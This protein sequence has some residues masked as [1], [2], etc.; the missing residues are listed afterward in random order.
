MS[1]SVVI[2]SFHSH[3]LVGKIVRNIDKKIPITIIE[4]SRNIALKKKLEK[5]YKNLRV[6]IPSKNLGFA[7]GMNLGIK[8][9]KTNYVFCLTADITISK[10][11]IKNIKNFISK[12]SDF[13][14]LAPTYKNEKIYKNYLINED[15]KIINKKLH[16][17]FGLSEVDWIDG[18]GFIYNKRKMKSIG[19][20][21]EKF[22]IYF[23]Q[24]DLIKRIKEFKKK[25]YVCKKIKFDHAGSKSCHPSK[26]NEMKLLLAWHYC[27]AKFY[28]YKKHYGYF[29]GIRKTIPNLLRSLK[30]IFLSLFK[31]ENEVKIDKARINGLINSYFL[32]KS[33]FR[34]LE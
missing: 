3:H 5:K 9:S 32:R 27:W 26:I 1:L 10:K 20:Y 2:L 12:F 14:L 33:S 25:I 15:K 8:K 6:I 18:G 16:N 4:N 29:V 22:F 23:E 24:E 13:A 31:N 17:K 34:L 11:C 21:D 30:K 28:F 7:P 19:L